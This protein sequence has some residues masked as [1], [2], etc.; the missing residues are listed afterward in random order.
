MSQFRRTSLRY[1]GCYTHSSRIA[2]A[3]QF[4]T[5]SRQMR[6]LLG[7]KTKQGTCLSRPLSAHN[8]LKERDRLDPEGHFWRPDPCEQ[9]AKAVTKLWRPDD[10]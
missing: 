1:R 7:L 3:S 9:T 4:L 6:G 2:P 5:C 10:T 8:R